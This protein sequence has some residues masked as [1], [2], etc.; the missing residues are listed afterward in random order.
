MRTPL[1]FAAYKS[2]S[3]KRSLLLSCTLPLILLAVVGC[4]G[5]AATESETRQETQD[6]STNS[7]TFQ[8][9][10]KPTIEH[11]PSALETQGGT[12]GADSSPARDL[13]PKQ[14]AELD[15]AIEEAGR[16]V[17]M[18]DSCAAEQGDNPPT[19]TAGLEV[20]KAWYTEA[21][22]TYRA[23]IASKHT[24]VSFEEVRP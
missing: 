3:S 7:G 16:L 14:A 20:Q 4:S 23:C 2:T 12:V 6:S 21:V 18:I 10:T 8:E 22:F 1:L 5:S 19:A 11:T 17:S 13:T 24:G 9:P 15:R